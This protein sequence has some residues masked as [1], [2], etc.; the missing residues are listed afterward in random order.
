MKLVYAG[1]IL[2]FILVILFAFIYLNY[3]D[4]FTTDPTNRER[5]MGDAIDFFYMSVTIQAGVGYQGLTPISDL[6]KMLLIFQQMCMIS[7]NI[8]I[9]YLIQ[10]HFFHL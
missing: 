9:V 7:S 5:I 3:A 8:L 2:N 1:V 10:L 4:Q 6:A